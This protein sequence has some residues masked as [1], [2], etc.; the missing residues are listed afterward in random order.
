LNTDDVGDKWNHDTRHGLIPG[1]AHTYSRGDDQFPSNAPELVTRG[2][3]AYIWGQDGRKLVDWAMGLRSVSLGYADRGVDRA[4]IRALRAGINLSRPTPGEFEL[5]STLVDLIPSAEMVKFG[6]NGSDA[7]A[8]AIRL[9]R[10]FT[11]RDLV[12]RC[13]SD[14]FLGVHDWFIGS[15]V[16]NTGVPDAVRELTKTFQYND[17]DS[18]SSL[19]ERYRGR[20]AALILEP[21]GAQEPQAGFLQGLR[22]ITTLNGIVLIFDE[23]IT[24]F[25]VALGGAQSLYGVLPD[26]STFGK[27]I[28]NGYPLSVL[29]GRK[30]IME[31]GGIY[32]KEK[33]VFLMSS[34]YGAE[35]ASIA[36]AQETISRLASTNAISENSGVAQTIMNTFR[37]W[38]G[39]TVLNDRI[40]TSGMDLLPVVKFHNSDQSDDPWLKTLFM[41]LMLCESILM[42]PYFL[43]VCASHRGAVVDRTVK[44]LDKVMPRLVSAVESGT[45]QEQVEGSPVRTVFRA[46]N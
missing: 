33:K 24:G 14:P 22:D 44:A 27:G 12:L 19:I 32:Y 37:S 25:R 34:T 6:K 39:H 8:A 40:S 26:L 4:A 21:V 29:A 45:V 5:A 46:S 18:V 38:V 23:T 36:A 30:S 17:L 15:T 20:V 42:A 7:T 10:A 41:Q 31:L 43:S 28:A 11:G 35:R 2:R 16:M 3:G 9:A 1:G 13:S